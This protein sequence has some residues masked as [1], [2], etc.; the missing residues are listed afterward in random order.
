MRESVNSSSGNIM[1]RSRWGEM[2]DVRSHDAALGEVEALASAAW[3]L[4]VA[5]RG[6][7]GGAL[8]KR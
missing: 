3:S 2:D 1:C 6:G 8:K 5:R 4:M 7:G